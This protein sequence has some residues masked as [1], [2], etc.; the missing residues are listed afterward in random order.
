MILHPEK[1]LGT[2]TA[3]VVA[4]QADAGVTV[5]VAAAALESDVCRWRLLVVFASHSPFV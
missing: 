1:S 4:V 2:G 3:F 5:P